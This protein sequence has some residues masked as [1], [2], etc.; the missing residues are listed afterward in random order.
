MGVNLFYLPLEED[1][2]E[3]PLWVTQALN[4][5]VNP[6]TK[7]WQIRFTKN[8]TKMKHGVVAVLPKALVHILEEYLAVRHL[9]V[10]ANKSGNAPDTVF[11]NEKGKTISSNA[12]TDLIQT[13]TFRYLIPAKAVNPHRFRDLFANAYLKDNPK[14]FLTLSKI[15]WHKSV[16]VTIDTYGAEFDIASGV[17]A[18]EAWAALWD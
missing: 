6:Q 7:F 17:C 3:I 18:A 10:Q 12:M 1:L 14:D 15:L 11:L 9:L 4:D 8:E 2:T 13:L 5:K 16:Q